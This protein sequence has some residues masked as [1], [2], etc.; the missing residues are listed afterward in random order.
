MGQTNRP[1]RLETGPSNTDLTRVLEEVERAIRSVAY[2][3]VEV[4]IQNSRVVQIERKEK[5]RFDAR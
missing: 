1:A 4:V 3:S 5:F 2:G